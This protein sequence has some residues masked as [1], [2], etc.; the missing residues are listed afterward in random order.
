MNL[1]DIF[2]L[3]NQDEVNQNV[4]NI[5]TPVGGGAKTNVQ[6]QPFL[7]KDQAKNNLCPNF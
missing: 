4:I 6:S 2:D 1:E 5:P 3:S 7:T